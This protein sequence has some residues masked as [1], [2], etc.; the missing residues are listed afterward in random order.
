[1][2]HDSLRKSGNH[3]EVLELSLEKACRARRGGGMRA[4]SHS[5]LEKNGETSINPVFPEQ[6]CS[7]CVS[8][9]FFAE[10]CD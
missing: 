5:F 8:F 1:M 2:P 6:A 9:G 7:T 3:L 4:T 10:W